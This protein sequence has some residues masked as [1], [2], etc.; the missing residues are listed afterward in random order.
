MKHTVKRASA[1]I[2]AFGVAMGLTSLAAAQVQA[3]G[4]VGMGLP[5]APAQA[6]QADD[7]HE[8]VVGTVGI[9]YLGRTGML[10]GDDP[11]G[12]GASA[13]PFAVDAPVIGIRYWVDEM[14][15]IDAGLG[16]NM[17]SQSGSNGPVNADDELWWAGILHIGVPLSLASEGHFS[18]QIVPEANVGYGQR[19]V[20]PAAA[21]GMP[22]PGD[23]VGTGFHLDVGAR[24]GAEIHFGFIDIPRLSLQ[25]T[26]GARLESDSLNW[27]QEGVAG[28]DSDASVF[29]LGTT[30]QGTPWNIFT[31]SIGA[32][33]YF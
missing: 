9:G 12:G 16:F 33:Y 23:Q 31:A 25:A 10:L 21:M 28:T 20:E 6:V 5:P 18:F 8:L 26:V 7:D 29:S 27:E 4:Q 14:L 2:F 30:V 13:T 15:G 3:Q 32:L 11:G 17:T 1:G 19:T 24:A 22:A